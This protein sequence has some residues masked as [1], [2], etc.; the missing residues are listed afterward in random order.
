[1]SLKEEKEKEKKRKEYMYWQELSVSD[2]SK[3]IDP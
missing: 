2:V 1:M 3:L